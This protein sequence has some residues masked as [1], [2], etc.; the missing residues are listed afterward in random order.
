MSEPLPT[1]VAS[2]L[3]G[4][5]TATTLAYLGVDYFALLGASA[6]VAWTTVRSRR[7]LPTARL[8]IQG[9]LQSYIGAVIGTVINFFAVKF[10]STSLP[11]VLII[12]SLVG[13]IGAQP[14]LNSL[15]D[16]IVTKITRETKSE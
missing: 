9:F 10:I 5:V 7:T 1:F 15:V 2:T 8:M 12:A 4:V 6:G 13:G 11:P 14:I 3:P 16:F